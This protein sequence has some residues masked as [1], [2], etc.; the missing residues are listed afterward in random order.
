MYL[1]LENPWVEPKSNRASRLL[2]I[3]G[4]A[5]G[6]DATRQPCVIFGVHHP[7]THPLRGTPAGQ[8]HR[9]MRYPVSFKI[10]GR[11][12]RPPL[13]LS[14]MAGVTDSPFRRVAKKCGGLGL[15]VT[16]FISVEGLTRGNMRSHEMMRFKPEE[17]PIAIQIFG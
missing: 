2:S 12:L 3:P 10:E 17:R 15:I 5:N 7:Q 8:N 13:V 4:Y 9:L 16:E 1:S 14:P 6:F 11:E